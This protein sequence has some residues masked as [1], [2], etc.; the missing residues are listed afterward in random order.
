MGIKRLAALKRKYGISYMEPP[1]VEMALRK[2]IKAPRRNPHRR[3]IEVSP[4]GIAKVVEKG[5]KYYFKG[6]KRRVRVSESYKKFAEQRLESIRER[7]TRRG[8]VKLLKIILKQ[9]K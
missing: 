6:G 2:V 9:G 4:E 7:A 5:E 8:R 1:E 3:V